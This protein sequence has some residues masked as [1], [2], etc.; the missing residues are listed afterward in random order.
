MFNYMQFSE[1]FTKFITHVDIKGTEI[2][3]CCVLFITFCQSLKTFSLS[4]SLPLSPPLLMILFNKSDNSVFLNSD[5]H[6]ILH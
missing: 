3:D 6:V 5:L 2:Y 1:M 4:L